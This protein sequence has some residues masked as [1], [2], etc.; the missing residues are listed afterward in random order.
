MF[1]T[2]LLDFGFRWGTLLNMLSTT[3]SN[4]PT[5]TL[6]KMRQ[7]FD[8]VSLY[9]FICRTLQ[10]KHAKIQSGRRIWVNHSTRV[11]I[12]GEIIIRV[13]LRHCMTSFVSRYSDLLDFA[14]H[15][16]NHLER[17]LICYSCST[18]ILKRDLN[19][20][21]G[22]FKFSGNIFH[23]CNRDGTYDWLQHTT[24]HRKFWSGNLDWQPFVAYSIGSVLLSVLCKR[25]ANFHPVIQT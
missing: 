23:R 2:I 24:T 1:C 3:R 19:N 8:I 6:K 7:S 16:V 14:L 9:L 13:R 11:I 22:F 12:E 15:C 17:A 21:T 20:Y 25:V 18:Y 4:T 10:S 5:S